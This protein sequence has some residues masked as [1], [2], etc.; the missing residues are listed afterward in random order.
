MTN[1]RCFLLTTSKNSIPSKWMPWELGYKDGQTTTGGTKGMVA[2]LSLSDNANRSFEGQEYLG[3][4]PHVERR[5]DLSGRDR[6]WI[7]K[8]E[9]HMRPSK[10]G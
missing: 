5:D 8:G 4:Y 3:I 10:V 9:K 7:F 2:I 6:L 1:S